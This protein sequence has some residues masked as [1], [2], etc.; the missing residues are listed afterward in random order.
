MSI[1]AASPIRTGS[2]DGARAA[3][4]REL[5]EHALVKER[6]QLSSGRWANYYIDAKRLLLSGRGFWL[7]AEVIAAEANSLRA[8]AVGGLTIGADPVAFAALAADPS[9]NAFLVRK[10]RKKH[11]LQRWIEGPALNGSDRCVV[12]DD[13][14]TSGDSVVDAIRRVQ[15]DRLSVVGV[16]AV[17]DRCEGGASAIAKVTDA[18]YRAL[19]TIDDVYPDR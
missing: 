4:A 14:V 3:L 11:G 16:L 9:L 12:V 13:V 5:A 6:V 2:L 10:Q 8:T 7:L 15:D 1:E 19:T 17:V 18:P